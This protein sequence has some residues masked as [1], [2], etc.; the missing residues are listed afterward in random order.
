MTRAPTPSLSSA[1]LAPVVTDG[2][3]VPADVL[4]KPVF[5]DRVVTRTGLKKRDVKPAVEA[6]LAVLAEALTNGEEL[7]LPPLGKLRVVKTKEIGDGAQAFTL[8]LRT[9]KDSAGA[10]KTGLAEADDDD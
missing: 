10:G 5:L 2:N 8:K 1:K 9:M 6:A 7:V 4:K 3:D